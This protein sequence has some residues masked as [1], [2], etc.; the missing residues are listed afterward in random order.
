MTSPSESF[1]ETRI[2]LTGLQVRVMQGGRGQPA[3][4]L[5][6]STGSPG[7]VPLFD[8][9][10]GSL[11]V[12]AP[13]MPGYGQSERPEWARDPRD[14]AMLIH[15]LLDKLGLLGNVNLIGA[16]FGGFVAAEM[17]AMNPHRLKSLTLIGAAGLQPEQGEILD[18]MV[19][20]FED[21]VK[22]SFRDEAAFAQVFGEHAPDDIKTLWDFS[23]E[24]TARVSWKP[25]MFDRRL[26]PLLREVQTPALIIWGEKDAIVPPVCGRQYASLLPNSRLEVVPGAGHLVEIEEPGLVADLIAAHAAKA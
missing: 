1:T 7:W 25:Y 20:D 15:L 14:L 4:F 11:A 8:K 6:H 19:V 23:R 2:P 16:G 12:S 17:A 22:A 18:Q 3:V 13:D 5:H 26:P 24:M 21:Y 10:A 9:L